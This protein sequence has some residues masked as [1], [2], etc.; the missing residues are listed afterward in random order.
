MWRGG[1][2]LLDMDT[3][4]IENGWYISEEEYEDTRTY[5]LSDPYGEVV[6]WRTYRSDSVASLVDFK[7]IV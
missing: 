5:S 1:G 2:R 4:E 7:E 6:Y 3:F